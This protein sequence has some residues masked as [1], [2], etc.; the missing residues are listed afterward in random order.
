MNLNESEVIR[1]KPL[2]TALS[3][4]FLDTE[5]QDF[6]LTDIA[7]KMKASGYTLEEID[8]I[9]R[10]EVFPVLIPNMASAAGEWAGFDE[11]WLHNAILQSKPPGTFRK[12]MNRISFRVIQSDWKI[13]IQ[14]YKSEHDS[15]GN[16]EKAPPPLSSEL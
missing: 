4:L 13:V 16:P 1:R 7:E 9:L 10:E 5:L 6:Q 2:W 11:E 3:D 14:K 8:R 12:V 15:S